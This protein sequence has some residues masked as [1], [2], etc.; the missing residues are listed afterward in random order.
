[1]NITKWLLSYGF[2]I[3]GG[4]LLIYTLGGV[5][6][7]VYTYSDFLVDAFFGSLF[8]Y[9]VGLIIQAHFAVIELYNIIKSSDNK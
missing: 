4:L 5:T 1:M 2:G 8:A 3:V 6:K 9:S 7:E